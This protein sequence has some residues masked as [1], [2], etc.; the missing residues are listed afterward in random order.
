VRELLRTPNS[1]CLHA[2]VVK[3][4][5][6]ALRLL[7]VRVGARVR[8]LLRSRGL[9]LDTPLSGEQREYL[10][11]VKGSAHALLGVLNDILDFSK[12]ELRKLELENIPFSVRDHVTGLLKP[13]GARQAQTTGAQ[14]GQELAFV[15]QVRRIR[16]ACRIEVPSGA[17]VHHRLPVARG[18]PREADRG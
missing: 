6:C 9:A 16:A 15:G 4:F 8:A 13:L 3:G 1:P 10:T 7:R 17:A 14:R 18:R 12:I 2:S 5:L 11:T